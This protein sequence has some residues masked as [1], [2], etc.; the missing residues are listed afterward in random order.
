[1]EE[2]KIGILKTE[3]EI[4]EAYSK[5]GDRVPK[6]LYTAL[7]HGGLNK[8]VTDP[9]WMIIHFL[10]KMVHRALAVFDTVTYKHGNLYQLEAHL[11]RFFRSMEL[12]KFKAPKT[13]AQMREILFQLAAQGKES[14]DVHIRYWCS[15]GGMDMNTTT[16]PAT[17]TIFYAIGLK[18]SP[19][20]PTGFAKAFTSTIPAKSK[21]L[22]EAKTTNYM[23]NCLAAEE[24]KS[25]GGL[26]LL[27]KPNGHV[28]E[29]DIAGY[30]FVLD[31]GSFFTP[32]YSGVL[33]STTMNRMMH[34]MGPM[35]KTGEIKGIKRGSM[36]GS[37]LKMRAREMIWIGVD[38]IVGIGAWDGILITKDKGSLTLKLQSMLKEDFKCLDVAVPVPRPKL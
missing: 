8:F 25:K 17:P 1:M 20:H 14:E 28:A 3:E 11:D 16:D 36:M 6:D 31:D 2:S 26:P 21:F 13:R 38:V 24:A 35:I 34:L 18:K 19:A 33:E 23:I 10:D 12:V 27:I 9:K 32:S 4:I 5:L 7:Y 37:E 30:A 15:R 29:A 22:A